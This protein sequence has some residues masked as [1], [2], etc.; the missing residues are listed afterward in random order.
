MWSYIIYAAAVWAV[1]LLIPPQ[2][3]ED[4]G[5]DDIVFDYRELVWYFLHGVWLG[6]L[7]ALYSTE[8]DF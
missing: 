6:G 3:S 4:P 8:Y 1:Y 7:S 5:R 2:F